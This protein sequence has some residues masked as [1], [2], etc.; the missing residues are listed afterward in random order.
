MSE[1]LA[2]PSYVASRC[3]RT[4]GDPKDLEVCAGG[5]VSTEFAVDRDA[6]KCPQ[7]NILGAPA[8]AGE[9]GINAG[10]RGDD[11]LRHLCTHGQERG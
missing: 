4:S 7:C 8:F 11:T 1:S 2:S 10:N 9:D 5:V 3:R 6:P